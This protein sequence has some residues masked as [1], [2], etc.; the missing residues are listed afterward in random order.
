MVV[1]AELFLDRLH[2]LAQVHLALPLAQLFLDLRLDLLLHLEHADLLLDVHEHAAEPFLDAQ[3]LEQALL[4]GRLKLDVAG[5]QVGETAGI[6]D[7]VE[8]LVHDFFRQTA[9]L[10]E[11]GGALAKLLVQGDER[12][13]V[14]VDR[15]HLLDGHH[16]GAEVAFGRVVLQG[17]G[18]LLALEQQLHA[19]QAALDLADARNDAHRV[20]DVRRRL[21]GI[22]ALGHG[23]H[24][25]LAF[26]RGLDGAKRSRTPCRNWRSQ[27]RE[28]DSS[29]Q[30]ENWQSLAVAMMISKKG[31]TVELCRSRTSHSM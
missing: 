8:H 18:A 19:A 2:L 25:A 3:R 15:L 29:P 22:V 16:D 21:V 20:E 13:V 14:L 4:F 1:V 10:A 27:P 31:G 7:G 6:G 23:E 9:A 11:L 12:R 5:D 28:N 24:E 17:G 26:Q 30:G